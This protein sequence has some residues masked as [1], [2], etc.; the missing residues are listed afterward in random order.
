M[1]S[2]QRDT[3][4]DLTRI[5]AFLCVVSVH[6]FSN[7]GYYSQWY[8]ARIEYIMMFIR[9]LS[10]VC[11]PLFLLLTGYL[12]SGKAI[13]LNRKS[14]LGYAKRLVPVLLTYAL[15]ELVILLFENTVMNDSLGLRNYFLMLFGFYHYSWYIEMYI[16]LF[17]LIPFLNLIWR[18][19]P[20]KHSRQCLIFV[21]LLLTTIPTFFNQLD[22]TT[23]GAV[24]D[25]GLGVKA[26]KLAPF[27]WE[28]LYPLTYYFLGAYFREQIDIKAL[29]TWKLS[30]L[31]LGFLLMFEIFNIRCGEYGLYWPAWTYYGGYQTVIIAVLVFL[32]INS[33]RYPALPAPA[34][35]GIGFVSKITLAAYLVSY[36]PD[37]YLYMALKNEKYLVIERFSSW[38]PTVAK[39]A[40]ISLALAAV[41]CFVQKLTE[42]AFSSALRAIKGGVKE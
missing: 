11:V 16:G 34:A 13:E 15:S 28:N 40:L 26:S 32:G 29:K 1:K 27:W 24:L 8:D 37:S 18:S 9:M 31:L 7:S 10:M 5:V 21:F 25:P 33:V 22:L 39:S 23:P 2:G 4:L 38:L 20:E 17:L 35:K 12:M 6:F 19:L 3:G 42:R 30:A 36:C 41:V 14:L